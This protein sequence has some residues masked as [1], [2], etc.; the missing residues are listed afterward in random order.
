MHG[1]LPAFQELLNKLLQQDIPC[2]WLGQP[3]ESNRRHKLL[4][5]S[6][7]EALPDLL[8]RSQAFVHHG[9]IGTCAQGLA[10]NIHQVI[11]PAAYDQHDNAFRV[12]IAQQA[13]T[14]PGQI[15]IKISDRRTRAAAP[16][17]SPS[18]LKEPKYSMPG[19]PNKAT[20]L[21]VQTLQTIQ[22]K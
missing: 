15:L 4:F 18:N 14:D 9:G 20:Y 16:L 13:M 22:R 2:V 3:S 8:A 10:Q 7:T 5:I 1:Q 12:A 6:Q 17:T 19:S 21:A 11:L